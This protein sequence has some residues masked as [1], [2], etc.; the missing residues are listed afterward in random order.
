[1]TTDKLVPDDAR[2]AASFRCRKSKTVVEM[3]YIYADREQ[4]I[5]KAIAFELDHR[6]QCEDC[7]AK[8]ML[9]SVDLP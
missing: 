9:Y 3:T 2:C 5:R 7:D 6:A 1:M 8:P 4:A